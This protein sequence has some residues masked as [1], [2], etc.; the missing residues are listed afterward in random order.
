[1]PD[2]RPIDPREMM[3]RA[4]VDKAPIGPAQQ[5]VPSQQMILPQ[6]PIQPPPA[7]TRPRIPVPYGGSMLGGIPGIAPGERLL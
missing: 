2:V 3:I 6:V 7:A 1:M 4:L 5:F